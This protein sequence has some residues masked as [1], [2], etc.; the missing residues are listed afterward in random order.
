VWDKHILPVRRFSL[1]ALPT[2]RPLTHRVLGGG[3]AF[4]VLATRTSRRTL[5]FLSLKSSNISMHY[6]C[7]NEQCKPRMN[8]AMA[9]TTIGH[10]FSASIQNAG[11]HSRIV[12]H[13]DG[14]VWNILGE[15][16]F[17]F[18]EFETHTVVSTFLKNDSCSSII[19]TVVESD[20]LF[21]LL[22]QLYR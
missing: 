12:R 15:D 9:T 2:R 4:P 20:E 11:V 3:A 16:C 1:S 18:S 17:F 10:R 19:F 14:I 6:A 5:T 7:A 13:A 22:L 8:A 21:F